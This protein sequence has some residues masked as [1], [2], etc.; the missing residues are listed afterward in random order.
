MDIQ[1]AFLCFLTFIIHLIGTLAY[2]VRIAGIRTRRIAISL[3][4]FNVLVLVSRTSNTF[5]GPFLAKR[6]ERNLSP[7]LADQLLLDF[8][9]L[10][11]TAAI[12]T[13]VGAFLTPTFQRLFTKAVLHFQVHR[14]VPRLIFEGLVHGG[15][16]Y[17]KDSFKLPNRATL[18]SV[19]LATGISAR[20]ILL[21]MVAV[22]LWTVGVFS[23][24]YAGCLNPELRATANNLSSVVNGVATILMFVF[25]DPQMSVMTD[26]VMEG[27]LSEG[28]F[29]RAV[30]WMVGSRFAGTLLA[31]AL[32]LPSAH[33][34]KYVAEVL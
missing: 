14:S 1:L 32:L 18:H 11:F 23:S 12:A 4:L 31:Q 16:G 29:R 19:G 9:W 17:V 2:S 24:F 27:H 20:V 8:R 34:V 22:S 21:N 13:V 10:L 33:V 6:I 26:D 3:A 25:I 28:A 5:Q 15:I 30:I 7:A